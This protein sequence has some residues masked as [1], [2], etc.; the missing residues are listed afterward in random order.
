MGLSMFLVSKVG[1]IGVEPNP[2]MK[3]MLYAMPVMMTVLFSSFA[4][5]L[6]L[7]Y[8]VQNL[9]SVPQQWLL[10]Q[11]RL[12]MKPPKKPDAEP[13]PAVPAEAGPP[14]PKQKKKKRR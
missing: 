2:Q 9:V 1:Q 7:Y 10:A 8:T 3:M 5:G 6:N 11:E 4:S 12:K 13:P 14:R